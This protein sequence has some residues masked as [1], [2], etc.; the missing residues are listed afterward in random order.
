MDIELDM[1]KWTNLGEPDWLITG[2][3]KNE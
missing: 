2:W 3:V 1:S